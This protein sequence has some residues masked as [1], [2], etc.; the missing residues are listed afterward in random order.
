MTFNI[1]INKEKAYL[2]YKHVIEKCIQDNVIFPVTVT[3]DEVDVYKKF[4]ISRE[5][6]VNAVDNAI[7]S[8]N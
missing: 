8:K 2:P 7:K 1:K 5:N 6:V 3:M 4:N